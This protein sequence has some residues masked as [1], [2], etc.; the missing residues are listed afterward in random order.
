MSL[1]VIIPCG[2]KKR[3]VASPAVELYTGPYFRACLAYA[4]EMVGPDM[5]YILSA[6]HGLLSLDQVVEPYNMRMGWSGCISSEAVRQQ[7]EERGLLEADPVLALGGR[8]YT[9]VCRLV[10]PRC[11]C[12]LE[13]KGGNGRQMKWLTT[14][15]KKR[16][17][18]VRRDSLYPEQR[19]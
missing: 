12:V 5:I 14:E 9:R 17:E 4:V 10:W 18:R 13:G 19:C 11:T 3:D 15:T 7:A 6:K 1:L 8:D 2:G 16:V